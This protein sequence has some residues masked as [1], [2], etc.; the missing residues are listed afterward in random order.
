M[1][2]KPGPAIFV[3]RLK[4]EEAVTVVILG[5]QVF[6]IWSHWQGKKSEPHFRDADTCPGCVARRPKRWKGY[7][8]VYDY[9]AN[10]EIF[11]ELTPH[12]AHQLHF[13]LGRQSELRGE[14]I[15]VAR[16][17]GDNG[18][19]TVAVLT[20]EKK[21]EAL[22]RAKDP[23]PT[24]LKLWGIDQEDPQGWL[25]EDHGEEENKRFSL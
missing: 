13:A 3:K 14:R 8:H 21:T 19:L 11:L 15:R 12:S 2:P 5:D 1:P 9:S 10:K 7:V 22:P 24:I 20:A 18:R 25:S 17:K 16:S 4:G 6:G 23:R